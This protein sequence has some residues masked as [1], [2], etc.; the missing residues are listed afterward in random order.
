[1]AI[2]KDETDAEEMLEPKPVTFEFDINAPDNTV[3]VISALGRY[4]HTLH[5]YVHV[6][7]T[8][9]RGGHIHILVILIVYQKNKCSSASADNH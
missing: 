2:A 8:I 3:E 7:C 5:V 6:L 4:Y 1:M 9:E